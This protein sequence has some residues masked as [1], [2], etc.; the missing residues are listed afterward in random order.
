MARCIVLVIDS[1][2]VGAMDDV[3]EV[4]PQDRGANTCGHIL[5]SCPQLCLP[6][7]ERLGLINALGFAPGVMQPSETAIW[8]TAELLHEGGDTFQ[9]HQEILGT[10]PKPP[11]VMAFSE[12]IDSVEARLQA[13]GYGA[14]RQ[15]AGPYWLL[16]NGCVAIGDNLEADPGQVYNITANLSEIAFSEVKAIGG[17]VRAQA[18]VGRVI[19]C[20]GELE[21]SRQ[22]IDAVEQRAGGYIGLN[23]P[24]SGVY[25]RGFQ[26]EH[27]GYGVDASVQ[28]PQRLHA[29]GVPT[30]LV[31][32]VADIVDNRC[33]V[34]W[35]NIVDSG[36]IMDITRREFLRRDPVFIC[37]NI[38]ETDLAGHA[39]DVERYIDRLRLVDD[40]LAALLPEMAAGD[41]LIVM[42]DHGNDPTIGHGRHTREKVPLLVYAPGARPARLGLRSTLSDVGATVCDFFMAGPPENGRSFL[43]LITREQEHD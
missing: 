5:Q 7:L 14:V 30:V 23:T 37:S 4:R 41:C 15:G 24:R 16:V 31:G 2:G 8:G 12:V 22:L 10:R 25:R 33:G 6:T 40:A 34:S 32:K 43:S 9:G 11:R 3:P 1:F 29:A 17:I 13:A 36:Q 38:Q 27:M 42:A 26:V 21:S 20:G 19:A 39:E 28:V 18:T 35:K